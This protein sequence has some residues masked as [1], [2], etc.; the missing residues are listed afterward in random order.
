MKCGGYNTTETKRQSHGLETCRP[1][2]HE[3]I[4]TNAFD[5]ENYGFSERGHFHIR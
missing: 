3:K 2:R 1:I 4:K 5:E